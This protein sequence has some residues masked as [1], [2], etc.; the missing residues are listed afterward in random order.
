V[1]EIINGRI[2]LAACMLMNNAKVLTKYVLL[3][4]LDDYNMYHR[5]RDCQYQKVNQKP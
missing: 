2:H 1:N 4:R 5:C 3:F